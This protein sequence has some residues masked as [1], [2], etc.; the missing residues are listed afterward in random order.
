MIFKLIIIKSVLSG[1]E[2]FRPRFF[3]IAMF[4]NFVQKADLLAIIIYF[5]TKR[6]LLSAIDNVANLR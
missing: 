2:I 3:V 4:N 1:G 6:C 5:R